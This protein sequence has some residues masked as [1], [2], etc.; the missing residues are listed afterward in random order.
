VLAAL[1]LVLGGV[2]LYAAGTK[3]ADMSAFAEQVANFRL[4][5]AATVALTAA[6]LPGIEIVTGALLVLGIAARAA[7]AIATGLLVVFTGALTLAL[8]RGINL[9]CGCFGGADVATWT[10]VARD[11]VL[12]VPALAVMIAGPGRL[13]GRTASG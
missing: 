12:L 5:P 2:F 10:T 8:A 6:T 4:L 1:R 11:I 7:A 13:A 3:L 9:E